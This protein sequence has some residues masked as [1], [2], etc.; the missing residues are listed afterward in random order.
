[1][2]NFLNEYFWFNFE[3]NIELNQF[4]A[5]FNVKMNNQNVP[6]TPSAARPAAAA[7]SWRP[8]RTALC[9]TMR[10]PPVPQTML[11]SPR[12]SLSL[13]Q[14]G[15]GPGWSYTGRPSRNLQATTNSAPRRWRPRAG[16]GEQLSQAPAFG[17][18]P[19]WCCGCAGPWWAILACCGLLQRLWGGIYRNLGPPALWWC[20]AAY[21]R[22]GLHGPP[23]FSSSGPSLPPDKAGQVADYD[24]EQHLVW[25]FKS[26]EE[27][28][29]YIA[30]AVRSHA[31]CHNL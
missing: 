4:L 19:P 22:A 8:S 17:R 20:A 14:L 1:M 25:T 21:L 3:L 18:R 15:Q 12:I 26:R 23:C 6:P 28:A 30:V 13:P 5:R 24:F 27:E 9:L 7:V 2:N 29:V 16:S 31:H 11:W 10:S